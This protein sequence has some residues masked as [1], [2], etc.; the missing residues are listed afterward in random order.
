MIKIVA[1]YKLEPDV[2]EEYLRLA[3]ELIN[4]TRREEGC[5]H[6]S[7]YEEITDPSI[8][9]MLEVWKDEDA[10]ISH[11]NSEHMKRIIPELEKLR[12]STEIN[13]Y[14]EINI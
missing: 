14:R 5:L 1:K 4:E 10:I 11:N 6:Y 9:A 7:I 12:E 8:L 2:K 13:L 3:K